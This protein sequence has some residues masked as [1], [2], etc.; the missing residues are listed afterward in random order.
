MP[1]PSSSRAKSENRDA[2]KYRVLFMVNGELGLAFCFP[3]N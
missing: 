1:V 2:T 3:Q